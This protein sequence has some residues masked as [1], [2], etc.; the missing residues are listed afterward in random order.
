MSHA[1]RRTEIVLISTAYSKAKPPAPVDCPTIH[2]DI[3]YA[4]ILHGK[5]D[6][7]YSTAFAGDRPSL[8]LWVEGGMDTAMRSRPE[9]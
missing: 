7:Y 3:R 6:R 1:F 4:W 9:V 8:G 2:I 5:V